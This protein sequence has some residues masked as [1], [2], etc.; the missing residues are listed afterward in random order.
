MSAKNSSSNLS[1]FA[2]SS[3]CK[4]AIS[5]LGSTP[6]ETWYVETLCKHSPYK[7]HWKSNFKFPNP[8]PIQTALRV[9][10]VNCDFMIV[11]ASGTIHENLSKAK[12]SYIL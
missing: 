12:G 1:V 2:A 5:T 11:T 3:S 6:C 10:R 7:N 4:L 8:I 9:Y